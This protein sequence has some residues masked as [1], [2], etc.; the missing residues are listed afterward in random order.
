MNLLHVIPY[1]APAWTY[2]G[3]VRA[4]AD[5]T[6]ALAQAGHSVTVLTTDTLSPTARIPALYETIDGVDVVR[7]RNRSNWLRGR[8]NLSTPL[9]IAATAAR[10][11]RER[12]IDVVHAHELRTVENLRVAPV[13]NRL[14]VPLL[15][16]P[17]GTLPYTTGRTSIKRLW[18]RAFG[19]RMLPRF[20]GVIALT[21]NEAA[22]ARAIWAACGAS[23]PDERIYT[24]PNGVHLGDFENLPPGEPFRARW[25]LGEGPVVLFLGRLHARKGLHLL[26]PAFAHALDA[27]PD[28]RLL[29]AG[30]DE[31]MRAM[32]DALV[33]QHDLGDRVIFTGM[34]TGADKLAALA[35]ADLF[36]LPAVGEGFSMAVLEAMACG[37]PVLLTPGC[38]FPE[39]AGQGA[40]LVVARTVD[41]LA[42]AL[43]ALLADAGR[44]AQMGRTAR[45][46]IETSYTWPQVA[47]QMAGVY[48]TARDRK[49]AAHRGNA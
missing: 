38:N 20:D 46:M 26:I 45:A 39:V 28:A 19:R 14:N 37:L 6:R 3:S 27:A 18:D 8:L 4:A 49:R 32:L 41:A 9:G 15:V 22:D 21:G 17:H 23:L 44:R 43:R 33:Q 13:A 7:V 24:V 10:L 1:Y 40:G 47:A 25:K 16:S 12:D 35:A 5:L 2:G 34:I 31:G 36:A 11:I 30:P 42:A 29:I 48:Q